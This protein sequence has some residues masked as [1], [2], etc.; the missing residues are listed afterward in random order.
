MS[1][2]TVFKRGRV[3]ER[4]FVSGRDS[5]ECFLFVEGAESTPFEQALRIMEQEYFGAMDELGLDGNSAVYRRFF[6]SDANNQ[7]ELLKNSP[8]CGDGASKEKVAASIIQQPP[9]NGSKIAMFA[10]HI[11]SKTPLQKEA[12]SNQQILIQRD[13]I[14]QLWFTNLAEVDGNRNSSQ[15]TE[16]LFQQLINVLAGHDATLAENVVRTWVYVR[17][18]DRN[19]KGMV[20]ARRDFFARHGLTADT[21]FIASTGIE[22]HGSN[23][24]T[25]VSLDALSLLGLQPNQLYYLKAYDY[26]C[27]TID[28]N[29]TFERGT[30]IA[31]QDR[32]HF[33]ISGTA[34]IDKNGDVTHVGDV[35]KQTARAFENTAALL[36][37]GGAKLS[38]LMYVLVYLRDLSDAPVV[39]DYLNNV[40][41]DIPCILLAAPVCR[42]K[43]LV[44]IEGVA[45]TANND[46]ALPE[47]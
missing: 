2:I 10:Y 15:Q 43:W 33:H 37:D 11:A 12:V 35:V 32:M 38:D 24:H 47:F 14:S 17:D 27:D 46:P 7:V 28:Y 23:A 30:R 22:G 19:Y 39:R 21:H 26:L 25:L 36:A 18:V 5:D 8:L 13:G 20:N 40:V 16:V 4:R 3:Q 42:P 9:L 6:V 41:S 31:F 34:S 45:I 44:E 29:V 1:E